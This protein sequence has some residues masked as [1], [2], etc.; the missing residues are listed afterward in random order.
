MWLFGIKVAA[1][2]KLQSNR[3]VVCGAT[4]EIAWLPAEASLTSRTWRR[5]TGAGEPAHPG[6]GSPDGTEDE[7]QRARR[8]RLLRLPYCHRIRH[9]LRLEASTRIG[10]SETQV[11]PDPTNLFECTEARGRSRAFDFRDVENYD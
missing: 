9:V 1:S 5:I 11:D 8:H 10:P 3:Q 4:L 6:K 2:G 7:A